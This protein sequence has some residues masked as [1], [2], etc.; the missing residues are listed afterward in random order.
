MLIRKH[1]AKI[2]AVAAAPLLA[3][4]LGTGTAHAGVTVAPIKFSNG[5]CLDVS[6]GNFVVGA[7]VQLWGCNGTSAQDW[8]LRQTDSTHFEVHSASTNDP[9]GR[10][11]CLNNWE[12]GDKTGN[13]MRLYS[14]S[15][16]SWGDTTF[17]WVY[18]GNGRQMQPRSASANC[19]NSWGG[20]YQGAE[21]RLYGCLD[22]VEE[23]IISYPAPL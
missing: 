2:A 23:N 10:M 9:Q 11:L 7:T 18:K 21:A 4:T 12:G 20:L 8:W 15:E 1:I 13:H 19:V 14:C 22:S 16:G 6:G 17:N 5:Y 3:A